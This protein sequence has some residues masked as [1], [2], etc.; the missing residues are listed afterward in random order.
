MALRL[1]LTTFAF[2]LTAAAAAAAG[3][4]TAVPGA[5]AN[6]AAT[7]AAASDLQFAL[8]LIAAEFTRQTGSAVKLVFGSSGD[9]RRQIA[10]GAPFELFLSAD[11]DLA[12]A[13]AKEAR[14]RDEGAV[15][16]IGR[17]VL[18]APHG[19]PL[20]PDA[21]LRDLAAAIADGRV[22]KFAIAN[23]GHAPYGAAARQALMRA[24]LWDKLQTRLVLGENVS[25]AAQFAMSGSAQGGIFAYSL[26]LSPAIAKLGT[27]ALIPAEMHEP[28]RQRMV[29]LKSAGETAKAF[30]RFLQQPAA[31]AMLEQYGFTLPGG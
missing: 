26:A 8:P 30:Y 13:L 25:Q 23:P 5:V 4:T 19:S 18:F 12:L 2:A 14:A 10:Q 1:P 3:A 15:Y 7:V 6:A 21:E 9:F 20:K 29:L 31:R 28:L 11:E 22:K 16:A 27:Y 24:G 17:I